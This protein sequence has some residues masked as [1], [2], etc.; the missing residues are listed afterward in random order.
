MDKTSGTR[1]QPRLRVLIVSGTQAGAAHLTELL[2][3]GEYSPVSCVYSGGDARR[4]LLQ[5]GFDLVLINTPLPDEFGQELAVHA[6]DLGL[7][8]MVIAKSEIF[9]AVSMEL[10]PLGI[11]TVQK[12]VSRAMFFQ[13]LRLM[14]ATLSRVRDFE[15]ENRKL[16]EKM[17]EVRIVA[18]AKCILVEYLRM[19]EQQAHRYIEKQAMDMR[20]SKR[21]IAE[22]ILK[23]YDV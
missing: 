13:A 20:I 19:S 8:A 12:P 9:E 3:P 16:R 2:S 7:G 11:L 21:S 18:R 10:A 4:L 14:T 6:A 15:E 17:E 22:R 1:S 23:T 5:D